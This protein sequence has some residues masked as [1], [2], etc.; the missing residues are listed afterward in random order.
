MIGKSYLPAV[1]PPKPPVFEPELIPAG[2]QNAG[3]SGVWERFK[4]EFV[5]LAMGAGSAFGFAAK[6]HLIEAA[7]AFNANLNAHGSQCQGIPPR[8]G[9]LGGRLGSYN[10]FTS[11]DFRELFYRAG[12]LSTL[13]RRFA[14]QKGASATVS[15]RLGLA[16]GVA[17][18]AAGIPTAAFSMGNDQIDQ[19]KRFAQFSA[20]VASNYAQSDFRRMIREMKVGNQIADSNRS[21]LRALD[22]IK[23]EVA[24]I[25]AGLIN[26]TNEI[27]TPILNYVAE[28]VKAVKQFA[29]VQEAPMPINPWVGMFRVLADA[30][31]ANPRMRGALKPKALGNPKQGGPN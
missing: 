28:G 12:N 29:G 5:E 2:G 3:G 30:A 23:D 31:E 24:P 14:T 6:M 9:D 16:A 22:N 20:P 21:L 10:V 1:I 8:F 11:R 7:A 18:F 4:K 25:G 15:G 27:L 13:T 17:G 19:Q 26:L